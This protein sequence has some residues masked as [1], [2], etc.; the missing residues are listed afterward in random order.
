MRIKHAS[1]YHVP[2]QTTAAKIAAV[3]DPLPRKATLR[4]RLTGKVI[5]VSAASLDGLFAVIKQHPGFDCL[6]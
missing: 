6:S 3:F 5:R 4:N 2:K 1:G